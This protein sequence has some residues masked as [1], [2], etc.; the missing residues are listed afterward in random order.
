MRKAYLKCDKIGGGRLEEDCVVSIEL[1]N[2]SKVSGVIGEE[3]LSEDGKLEVIY[4]GENDDKI[5]IILPKTL[6]I[7]EC[8]EVN[9]NMI[10]EKI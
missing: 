1:A 4:L 5:T 10:V 3:H 8:I 7:K 2:G 6:G 9:P